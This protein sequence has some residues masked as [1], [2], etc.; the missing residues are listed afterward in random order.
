M[1]RSAI[2]RRSRAG[3]TLIELLVV[4]AIIG[5]LVAL[6]LP[7]VQQARE[8]ARRTQCINNLKQLGLAAQQYH[9]AYQ[10]FPSGWFCDT[11]DV[12]CV[13]YQA[14]PYMWNGFTGLFRYLENSNLWNDINFNLPPQFSNNV[15]SGTPTYFPQP[16]NATAIRNTLDVFV[17]PS[18]RQARSA[19]TTT[20]T[21]GGTANKNVVRM[22]PLDYRGNMAAGVNPNCT[23]DIT[24][25][26]DTCAYYDNGI[27]FQNSMVD[28]AAITDGTS[29]TILFGETLTGTWPDATSC[30][31]RST[32]DRIINR[33]IPGSKITYYWASKH[34]GVVNFAKCD[35]TVVTLNEQI[36]RDVLL[37][38]MTRNG[39]ETIS[40]SDVK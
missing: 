13:P 19:P 5:V 12:N 21:S 8:S 9:D 4:I 26:Y 11:N 38:L 27:M 34:S 2:E 1:R 31:I 15:G 22:G 40:S 7:A 18:N 14:V 20:S 23:R 37:K 33:L 35:G 29:N 32:L 17:C 36:R 24:Q 10:T 30:C 6:I 3:F 16:D 25:P 39:G 28:I